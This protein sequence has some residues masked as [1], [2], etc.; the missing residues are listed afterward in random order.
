MAVRNSPSEKLM[1]LRM[2]LA[3]LDFEVQ[4]KKGSRNMQADA[5]SDLSAQSPTAEDEKRRYPCLS[6]ST[7]NSRTEK[8]DEVTEEEQEKVFEDESVNSF[9]FIL[10]C[11]LDLGEVTS[12]I[13][14]KEL[15]K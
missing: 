3:E 4:H 2:L 8:K 12:Q 5:I 13:T 7:P 14:I 6:V 1:R 11:L 10:A 15:I 9:D